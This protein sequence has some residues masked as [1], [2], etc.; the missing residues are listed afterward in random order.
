MEII[1]RLDTHAGIRDLELVREQPTAVLRAEWSNYANVN[2]S[3]PMAVTITIAI[4]M[5]MA[6]AFVGAA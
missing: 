6:A 2:T 1:H 5:A 4:A 3:M